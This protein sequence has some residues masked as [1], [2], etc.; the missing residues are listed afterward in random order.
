MQLVHLST[1]LQHVSPPAWPAPR[2]CWYTQQ[3]CVPAVEAI[4]YIKGISDALSKSCA[5]LQPMLHQHAYNKL[6]SFLVTTLPA[7]LKTLQ[8]GAARQQMD[9]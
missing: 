4:V 6:R 5:W 9:A 2:Y 1:L 3:D 8:V 7:V